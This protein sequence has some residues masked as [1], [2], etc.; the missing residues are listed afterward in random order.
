MSEVRK[1]V[2]PIVADVEMLYQVVFEEDVTE[3][4]AIALFKLDKYVDVLSEN[5]LEMK[6]VDIYP[7]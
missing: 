7:E 3:E 2:W 5:T 1:D 6:S 4:E